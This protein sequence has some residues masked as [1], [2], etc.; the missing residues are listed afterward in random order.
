MSISKI[1]KEILQRWSQSG[2]LC[3]IPYRSIKKDYDISKD[4]NSQIC[5]ECK[6]KCC[7]M[8]GCHF[9]PDDF[10]EISFEYLKREIEKGY[11]SIDYV[12]CEMIYENFGVYILRIRN[13]NA[14]IVDTGFNRRTPCILL[15][16]EGCKLEYKDRPSGGKLLVPSEKFFKNSLKQKERYCY[17]K[18]T[19]ENC[20]YE[21][22]PHQGLIFQLIK[23]FEK[24]DIPCSL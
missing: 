23:N 2:N 11:I 21:W 17:Q 7:K 22:K 5:S 3:T 14:P 19:I 16:D 1:E 13:A 12:D 8:C 6:G 9:S 4:V 20:C 10:K 18:Y 24:K 15:T